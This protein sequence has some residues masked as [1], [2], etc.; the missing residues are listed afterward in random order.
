MRLLKE[1]LILA[2]NKRIHC[3]LISYFRRLL[4]YNSDLARCHLI[5]NNIFHKLCQQWLAMQ[6]ALKYGMNYIYIYIL[7]IR[8]E[9]DN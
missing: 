7:Q 6:D 5:H 1:I 9:K 8:L 2:I 4:M 3:V